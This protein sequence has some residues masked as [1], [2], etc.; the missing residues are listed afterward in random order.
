LQFDIMSNNANPS[1]K[2][3]LTLTLKKPRIK[4]PNDVYPLG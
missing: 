3:S 2:L 4:F 1:L